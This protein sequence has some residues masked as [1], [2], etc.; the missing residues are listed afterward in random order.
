MPVDN[1]KK[2]VKAMS[3]LKDGIIKKYCTLAVKQGATDAKFVLPGSVKTAEWVR[4]K[5]R[6]GC[7][8]YGQGHCC[9]PD[10]PAPDETRKFL[11]CYQRAILFHLQVPQSTVP[12]ERKLLGKSFRK[13]HRML[14]KLEGELFKEGYY[15][16]FLFLAGPC[17]MCKECGKLKGELCS[18]MDT[19]RPAMEACGI[20]VF[21]T[22]RNNGYTIDTLS[23][24]TETQNTYCLMMVD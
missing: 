15:K 13:L 6:F 16:A 9:P 8:A 4:W 11:D 2:S 19:A 17:R 20:D 18:M 1:K 3:G 22:A 21:Q 10:T 5:C 23:D 12:E 14:V 7:P 24:K